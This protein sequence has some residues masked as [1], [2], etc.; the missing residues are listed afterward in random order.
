MEPDLETAILSN[1]KKIKNESADVKAELPL[2]VDPE[3]R[4]S[5]I[6]DNPD[7]LVKC[8][9]KFLNQTTYDYDAKKFYF[10]DIYFK[11]SKL[12]KV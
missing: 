11:H 1:L 4:S 3:I 6:N 10:D 9:P 7:E 8:L 2:E 12:L 5:E